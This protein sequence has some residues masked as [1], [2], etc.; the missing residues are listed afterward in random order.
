MSDQP[1]SAELLRAL[2]RLVRGL[3]ALFWGL[4]ASLVVGFHTLKSEGMLPFG[5]I[6]VLVCTAILSYGLWLLG[7]F[8]KQERVWRTAL[9]RARQ[10]VRDVLA[11]HQP[12]PLA[13]G[14]RRELV[15]IMSADAKRHGLDYLPGV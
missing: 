15:K 9:D 4:P 11:K 5:Y 13:D 10:R 7:D 8:Q 3:S 2:G 6:P 14:V 12:E 1:P